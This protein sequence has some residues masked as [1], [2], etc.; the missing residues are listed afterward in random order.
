MLDQSFLHIPGIGPATELR[1][2]RR[3]IL[4][5]D[6]FLACRDKLPGFSPHR[7]AL[8]A[9]HVS[10]SKRCLQARD[11]HYFARA[12]P[13]REAW[14]AWPHFRDKAAYLD[15]ET[16]G[17]GPWAEVTMVGLYDGRRV[18]TYI[19]GDN[20]D[21]LPEDLQQ[22]ALLITF[23]GSTFD[24]PFLRRRFRGLALPQIHVDLRYALARLGYRGGLKSIETRL[25]VQ[26]SKRTA[27][28]DGWDAVRL[29]N[30][31]LSGSGQSLELLIEYNTEDIVNLEALMD[32]AYDALRHQTWAAVTAP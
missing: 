22:F 9:D 6:D 10:E 21:Q 5:W 4:Y 8:M 16:T 30:E 11:F 26:R 1:L 7:Q 20:L 3:G 14:R 25:G 24:L 28:L 29:W 18:R 31:Y 32:V 13:T 27:G 2:W 17:M 15:I 19:H 23:N 12:L